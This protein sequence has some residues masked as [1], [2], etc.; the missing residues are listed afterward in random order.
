MTAMRV[1]KVIIR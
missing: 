1:R